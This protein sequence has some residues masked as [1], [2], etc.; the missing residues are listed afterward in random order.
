MIFTANQAQMVLMMARV[1]PKGAFW[2]QDWEV[3]GDVL[4]AVSVGNQS[5]RML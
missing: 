3:K 5:G 2:Q 4:E 1:L